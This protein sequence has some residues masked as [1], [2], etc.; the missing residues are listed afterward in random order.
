MDEKC[1]KA[2]D[3]DLALFLLEP[4]GTEWQEF[5]SHYPHCATCAAEVQKWTSLEL[6]LRT[7]GNVGTNGHPAV[8]TLVSFQRQPPHLALDE[9]RII[10]VHLRACAACRE[11]VKLLGSFDLSQVQHWIPAAQPVMP[12]EVEDSWTTR[13]WHMLRSLFLHPAFAVG[14]VLLLSAP[15]IRSYYAAS[16]RS[17]SLSSEVTSAPVRDVPLD[18]TSAPGEQKV[19]EQKAGE[20]KAE[21]QGE[22]LSAPAPMS[23][24]GKVQV[25]PQAPPPR[26][27]QLS[28]ASLQQQPTPG[29]A[30]KEMALAKQPARREDA[31]RSNQPETPPSPRV[32]EPTTA[33]RVP[34]FEATSEQRKK[35]VAEKEQRQRLA[36]PPASAASVQ[37]GARSTEEASALPQQLEATGSDHPIVMSK[38]A[39]RM[40]EP[41][42]DSLFAPVSHY[43]SALSALLERYKSAYE[44]RNLPDLS[45]IW[46]LDQSWHDALTQ[47][48]S[49]SQRVTLLVA[50]DEE[51]I[52][53]SADERQFSVPLSHTLT[54]TTQDGQIV[55]YPPFLC[56][57]DIRLQPTGTW[58]IHALQEDPQHPERCRLP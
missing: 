26:H 9:Q 8:E 42:H 46:R 36:E 50:L 28:G 52:V 4:H 14:L 6:G 12:I 48:F 10:A 3:I 13:T 35:A 31:R 15:F 41:M 17:S 11:E 43:R 23:A 7:L 18:R 51:Q 25:A 39:P 54:T 30:Q 37:R 53:A 40:T 49:H 21:E 29:E 47:L 58:V 2:Q 20:Q 44:A 55:Q 1:H 24:P 34:A 19:G 32:S 45:D 5:R 27:E 33:S 56:I 38:A 22:K 57:A 16:V